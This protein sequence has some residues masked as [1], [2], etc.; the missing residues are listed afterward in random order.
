MECLAVC[1]S[2]CICA[3]EGR[4]PCWLPIVGIESEEAPWVD[5]KDNFNDANMEEKR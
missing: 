1:V 3:R 4:T 5:G 2:E